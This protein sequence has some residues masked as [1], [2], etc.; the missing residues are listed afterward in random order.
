MG[1]IPVVASIFLSQIVLPA[2]SSPSRSS[3]SARVMK[4][5]ESVVLRQAEAY[6]SQAVNRV[7]HDDDNVIDDGH[8]SLEGVVILITGATSGIGQGL[9]KWCHR[10][11]ATV[12]VMG[13]SPSKLEVLQNELLKNESNLKIDGGSDDID[14]QR[15]RRVFPVVA[16]FDNLASVAA[17]ADAMARGEYNTSNKDDSPTSSFPDHID[18]L[19]KNAG[20]HL[21]LETTLD[22][23]FQPSSKQ[24]YDLVFQVNYLAHFLL[25]EKLLPTML[26]KSTVPRVVQVSSSFHFAVDGSDLSPKDHDDDD[27][28]LIA[29]RPGGSH[30]FWAFRSQRQ[31]ANS[32]LAQILH[33]RALQNRR[34]R[35]NNTNITF[36]SACPAWV[37]TSIISPLQRESAV[38]SW[39]ARVFHALAF[40]ADG[41]GLSSILRAMFDDVD[42]SGSGGNDNDV[43][44][45]I[46]MDLM[47]GGRVWDDMLL[48]WLP[49]RWTY[50]YL[51]IRDLVMS[52]VSFLCLVWQRFFPV[53]GRAYSST[54]SYD[55][56]LQ[57]DLY[58]WSRQAVK[59]WL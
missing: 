25:T 47:R 26:S 44:Y 21:G 27:G 59:E 50:D 57:Q 42:R 7:E 43:D 8:K 9:T 35:D 24:G 54:A 22:P 45:F 37:G 3:R 13:R 2:G 11:G 36:A 31:Y 52:L 16:D 19:V 48:A 51:P 49:A 53:L 38:V 6:R 4:E 15:R 12:I 28:T 23:T 34:K 29:S 17:A 40:S 33:A 56:E 1:V 5:W 30:G 10:H 20:M 41:Y 14:E 46:N 58:E 55:E 18:I 32:K 39:Q